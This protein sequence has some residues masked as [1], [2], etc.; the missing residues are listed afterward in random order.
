MNA[1]LNSSFLQFLLT[2]SSSA[3]WKLYAPNS[4]LFPLNGLSNAKVY[5]EPTV[6]LMGW[7]QR[8]KL[9]SNGSWCEHGLLV[10]TTL[11][12][13]QLAVSP[14]SCLLPSLSHKSVRNGP[15]FFRARAVLVLMLWSLSFCFSFLSM[16]VKKWECS[17]C[18][19]LIYSH[20]E[21]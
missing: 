4:F 5:S 7:A 9:K 16:V 21:T 6:T 20:W 8:R 1:K 10:L 3:I 18:S 17:Q 19:P 11:D 12:G 15:L 14:L 13:T 2:T